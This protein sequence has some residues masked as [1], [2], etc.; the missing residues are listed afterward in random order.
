LAASRHS[1][2]SDS[3]WI[4]LF[5]KHQ[6]KGLTV[7]GIAWLSWD[8]SILLRLQSPGIHWFLG[9]Y[10]SF[11]DIFQANFQEIQEPKKHLEKN[12]RKYWQALREF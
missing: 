8:F 4:F 1:S 10:F 12:P 9:F 5:Y 3:L 2:S 7:P 6:H 11:L